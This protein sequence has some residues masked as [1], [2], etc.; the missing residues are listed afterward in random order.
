MIL[1]FSQN[2]NKNAPED[3]GGVFIFLAF[4]YFMGYYK[5]IIT[6]EMLKCSENSLF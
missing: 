5:S 1:H 4:S 6:K 2:A 3:F